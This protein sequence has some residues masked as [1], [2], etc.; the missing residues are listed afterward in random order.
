TFFAKVKEELDI[1][2]AKVRVL[3]YMQ[4]KAVFNNEDGQSIVAAELPKHPLPGSLGSTGLITH[5]ITS[6][7]VD[8][9]PLY[10]IE[11]M[12][13]R[14]GGELSRATLANYVMKSAKVF[15]PLVNLLREHQNSGD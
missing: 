13:R 7:Y 14:Y 2:P 1:V 5:A 15:Q 11:T 10:R 8:G 4:E 9:L 12:L 6:K 3:E